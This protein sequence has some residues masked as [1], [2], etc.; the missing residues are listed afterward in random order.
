[1]ANLTQIVATLYANF[2]T[3]NLD[4]IAEVLADDIEWAHS[5][6]PD[7]PY[8]KVRRGKAQVMTFFGDLADSVEI[9]QFVPKTYIE[10]GNTVVALGRWAGHAKKTSKAFESDWAMV[11]AFAGSKVKSYQAFEDTNAIAKAFR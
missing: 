4:G 9:T 6:A 10:Q 11:W 5:G 7:L 1:M 2:G 8:A 3:G